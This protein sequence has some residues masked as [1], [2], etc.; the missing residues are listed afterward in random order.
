MNQQNSC[1]DVFSES[2]ITPRSHMDVT[3]SIGESLFSR[4]SH[5]EEESLFSRRSLLEEESLFFR[6]STSK[7]C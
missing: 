4:R 3:R 2:K 5:L 7:E 6:R 1:I